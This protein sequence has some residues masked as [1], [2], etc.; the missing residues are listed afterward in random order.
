MLHEDEP[1]F[2]LGQGNVA[3]PLY[4]EFDR[5]V[6]DALGQMNAASGRLVA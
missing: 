3:Y 1:V 2:E 5:T 4:D 6:S